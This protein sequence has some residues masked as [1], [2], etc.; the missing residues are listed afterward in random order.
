MKKLLLATLLFAACSDRAVGPDVSDSDAIQIAFFAELMAEAP[1]QLANAYCLSYGDWPERQ[2]LSDEAYGELRLLYGKAELASSCVYT[3]TGVTFEGGPARGFFM[4]TFTVTGSS[5]DVVG[6]WFDTQNGMATYSARVQ[7]QGT[8]WVVTQF[9][10][11]P[12]QTQSSG[13]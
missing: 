4:N 11:G 12:I 8:L 3:E 9:A 2:D 5:V 1:S 7:R 10:G 6:G 13:R